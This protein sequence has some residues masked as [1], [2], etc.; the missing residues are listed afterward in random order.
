MSSSFTINQNTLKRLEEHLQQ[1][2]VMLGMQIANAAGDRAPYKT[3]ALS[4]SIRVESNGGTVNV[5]AGGQSSR[6]GR[7]E[8]ARIHEYG[9]YTGKKYR[10]Y[11]R[12]RKYM[13]QA[14]TTT[15]SG[16]WVNT[17]FGGFKG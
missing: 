3:G 5:L 7:I 15:L 11:I 14:F 10:T 1:G 12:P 4:N 17:Y 2:V 13:S 16:D 9:G 8:Y 6:G